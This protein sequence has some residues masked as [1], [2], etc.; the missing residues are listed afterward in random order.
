MR[1]RVP[2]GG[3]GW[4]GCGLQG[5]QFARAPGQ[6]SDAVDFPYCMLEALDVWWD[7]FLI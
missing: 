1:S 5:V 6:V 3:P 7:W 2:V 4:A